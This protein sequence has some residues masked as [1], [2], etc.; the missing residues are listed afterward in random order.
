M[1]GA[2]RRVRATPW[3]LREQLERLLPSERAADAP[4]RADFEALVRLPAI[5]EF[6]E[7]FDDL[8]PLIL[9]GLTTGS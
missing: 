7:R 1:S 2:R 6:A 4:S 8:P 3:A 9:A 5:D